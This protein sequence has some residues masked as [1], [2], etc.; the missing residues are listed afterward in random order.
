MSTRSVF[1][2]SCLLLAIAFGFLAACSTDEDKSSA[3]GAVD[4]AVGAT[5]G[6]S[7]TG[8]GAGGGGTSGTGGAGGGAGTAPVDGG[9]DTGGAGE[10]GGAGALEAGIDAGI[11]GTLPASG[12]L[13]ITGEPIEIPDGQ[14][15]TVICYQITCNGKLL[16]CADCEDNDGDGLIDAADLECLGPCDNTEGPVLAPG[17][18]GETGEQCKP[19]DCFFDFGNGP[20]NDD[21]YWAYFC[22]P[23]EPKEGCEY[24]ESELGKTDCPNGQSDLCLQM[25]L[26]IT[27]NGCDCFGCCT[28]PE[29][30]GMGDGGSDGHVWIGHED[31]GCT[32]DSVTDPE[33]CPPCTPEPS[34]WNACGRCELCLG[35][36]TIPDDCFETPP[37]G[38]TPADGGS[39]TGGGG[40]GGSGT[41]GSGTAGSGGSGSGGRCPPGIQAC[42]LPSDPP[43]PRGTYCITGC[44]VVVVE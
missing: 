13:D 15:G 43:C 16:E 3:D 21:C 9:S 18:G 41:G 24:D 1:I 4:G 35:K 38:G 30:E 17:V 20:G 12:L 11:W 32:L 44:C 42:G 14:G 6:S 39:G 26:P 28:F 23:L 7:A 22:D 8:G 5:D 34:C 36:T 10:T 25:C 2:G 29:L 40:T 37:D 31:P 33:A 27:P 19:R